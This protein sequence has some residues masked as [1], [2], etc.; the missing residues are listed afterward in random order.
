MLLALREEGGDACA[1]YLAWDEGGAQGVEGGGRTVLRALAAEQGG[2]G[3]QLLQ[4]DTFAFAA[5]QLRRRAADVALDPTA[6]SL[7]ISSRGQGSRISLSLAREDAA[8]GP[9]LYAARNCLSALRRRAGA[10]AQAAADRVYS[11][12]PPPA[13]SLVAGR[14]AVFRVLVR[15]G[16]ETPDRVPAGRDAFGRID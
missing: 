6:H 16:G 11:L 14:P 3:G 15:T 1:L 2:R 8:D 12:E 5:A 10:V 7:T 4:R 13:G 9:V